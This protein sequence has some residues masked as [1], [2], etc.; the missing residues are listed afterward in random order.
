[1]TTRLDPSPVVHAPCG[2]V[3]GI[4]RP[5]SFAFLGIPFAKAPIGERRF[6]APEP[7]PSW[8]EPR[9][10]TRFGATPQRRS[11]WPTST[12][13][14]PIIPGEETLN[15]NV[16]TPTPD[17][18]AA[19]PV[20]VYIHGGGYIAGSHVGAWFDGATYNRDGVIVVTVS[21]RLGFDGFGWIADAPANRGL[22]DLVRALT[23]VQENIAAFGGDPAQVTISGQSAGGG[24]VLSLLAMPSAAGLFRAAI[25]HSPVIGIATRAQHEA[26]GRRLAASAGVEPT[27]AGWSSLSE[28]QLLDVQ[29]DDMHK[30]D[31]VAERLGHPQVRNLATV[32]DALC[33]VVSMWGPAIDAD[34][35]PTPPY[36]AWAMGAAREVP[37]LIGATLDE[38]V[39]PDG[40][41][42]SLD[43]VALEPQVRAHG[44]RL[45]AA[46]EADPIGRIAGD[47]MF[48]R[49]VLEVAA[50]RARG[51]AHTWLYDFAYRGGV[52]GL[53]GHCHELPFTWDAL[54]ADGVSAT[55]GAPPPQELA[56]A[57]H[58]AWVSFMTH[59]DPGWPE[60]GDAVRGRVFGGAGDAQGSGDAVFVDVRSIVRTSR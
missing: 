51:G 41:Q 20:H 29:Y 13:P 50:A 54:S 31:E 47:V 5:G 37:L 46:G 49:S 40:S 10:A 18:M 27:R 24:A 60:T 17:P 23:W 48:R 58:G 14:E 9:D 12:I 32:A 26:S 57:M 38:F 19:L 53:A 28:E 36:A 21:Y 1:M 39:S 8:T 6:G 42:A 11:P 33:E 34:T 30:A 22:L 15:C 56:D 25:A 7:M 45:V 35:L 52:S 3:R 44:E 4:A 59:G 16:F 55:L 43:A 2:P